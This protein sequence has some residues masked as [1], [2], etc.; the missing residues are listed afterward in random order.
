ML[1][2]VGGDLVPS[3][4]DLLHYRMH[5]S[6]CLSHLSLSQSR[7][8]SSTQRLLRFT[9]KIC[10]DRCYWYSICADT[11]IFCA[12][13]KRDEKEKKKER[14]K[15]H[16]MSVSTSKEVKGLSGTAPLWPHPLRYSTCH[17]I[18]LP[19]MLISNSYFFL[20]S[21]RWT[22]ILGFLV[23]HEGMISSSLVRT[24]IREHETW[25]IV[26]IQWDENSTYSFQVSISS[27]YITRP[28]D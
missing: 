17:P 22:R 11:V 23:G 8:V 18:F 3:S 26:G 28:S 7:F 9:S 14:K 6:I 25:E 12:W 15:E 19:L 16:I 13:T 20:L 4:I 24:W 27:S 5:S 2:M 10:R 1:E 21:R